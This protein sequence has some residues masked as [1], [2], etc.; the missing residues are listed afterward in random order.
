MD[1]WRKPQIQ[2]SKHAFLKNLDHEGIF[3]KEKMNRFMDFC[4]DTIFEMKQACESNKDAEM[5]SRAKEHQVIN[6]ESLMKRTPVN[7]MD[8]IAVNY[9]TILSKDASHWEKK[10]IALD[11]FYN[12]LG[13]LKFIITFPIFIFSRLSRKCKYYSHA[14]RGITTNHNSNTS[15]INNTNEKTTIKDGFRER[16]SIKSATVDYWLKPTI[17]ILV[18]FLNF[19]LFFLTNNDYYMYRN[20][21]NPNSNSLYDDNGNQSNMLYTDINSV[22][23]KLHAKNEFRVQFYKNE[24]KLVYMLSDRNTINLYSHENCQDIAINSFKNNR[25]ANLT[26]PDTCK[27]HYL[28]CV[29]LNSNQ[30]NTV[31]LLQSCDKEH[32]DHSLRVSEECTTINITLYEKLDTDIADHSLLLALIRSLGTLHFIL[33]VVLIYTYVNLKFPLMVF[34]A[35]KAVSHELDMMRQK[36]SN[37]STIFQQEW[38]NELVSSSKTFP[39]YWTNPTSESDSDEE[40]DEKRDLSVLNKYLNH[41][42]F[43]YITW[44]FI[45]VVCKDYLFWIKLIYCIS[46]FFGVRYTPFIFCTH[47]LL[48]IYINFETLQTI[49]Y[50]IYLNRV[51]LIMSILIMLVIQMLFAIIGLF[52]FADNFGRNISLIIIYLKIFTAIAGGDVLSSIPNQGDMDDDVT[53]DSTKIIFAISYFFSIQLVLIAIIQGLIID[54]FGEIRA[55]EEAAREAMQTKCF[56]CGL[57]KEAFDQK[58]PLGFQKHTERNHYYPNYLFFLLYLVSKDET[59]YTGQES[60]VSE[61]YRKRNFEFF[62]VGTCFSQQNTQTRSDY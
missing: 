56:I 32:C 25:Y 31:P 37:S 48:D 38:W 8:R 51:R 39:K 42:D 52:L 33:S 62:P 40:D 46:S 17:L 27:I 5:K 10:K 34:K 36:S 4:E 2:D 60:Y 22:I 24:Q 19:M 57:S 3:M 35:E 44:L 55:K 28:S 53:P 49:V 14:I 59:E 43:K 50:S 23:I 47:L 1:H 21:T 9:K 11:N 12:K 26:F 54:A 16:W 58:E 30:T 7:S 45:K 41:I 20:Q 61:M 15:H 6:S 29:T 13:I 18:I